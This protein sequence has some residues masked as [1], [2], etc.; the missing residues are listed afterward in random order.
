MEREATQTSTSLVGRL[1]E[2][3]CGAS[4]GA[5][6]GGGEE[7]EGGGRVAGVSGVGRR[8]ITEL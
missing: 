7:G 8:K 4:E 6:N 1:L 5:G 3:Y 2:C